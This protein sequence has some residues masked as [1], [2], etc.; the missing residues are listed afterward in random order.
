MG[1][2]DMTYV[3]EL[4]H[5]IQNSEVEDHLEDPEGNWDKVCSVMLAQE[6]ALVRMLKL[7]DLMMEKVN[8]KASF[9]DADCVREMNEAPGQARRALIN[10]D[11]EQTLRASTE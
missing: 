10:H 2:R 8:H 11:Y 6:A 3:E 9:Y 5:W 4:C 1:E 7:Y